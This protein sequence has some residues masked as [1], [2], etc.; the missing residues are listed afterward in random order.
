M[1]NTPGIL[2]DELR[3]GMVFVIRLENNT[4]R[5]C[6]ILSTSIP[7][8]SRT[9]GKKLYVNVSYLMCD[10]DVGTTFA[11]DADWCLG[12]LIFRGWDRVN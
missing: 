4:L 2:I 10:T 11:P 8:K 7:Y 5:A 1:L 9:S 6:I 3:P 12:T